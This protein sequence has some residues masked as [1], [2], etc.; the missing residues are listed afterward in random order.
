MNG[1][2]ELNNEEV[3]KYLWYKVWSEFKK[4]NKE[5][6]VD[7]KIIRARSTDTQQLGNVVKIIKELGDRCYFVEEHYTVIPKEEAYPW[8]LLS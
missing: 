5:I 4:Q 8:I 7:E 2:V 1:F 6:F 3:P